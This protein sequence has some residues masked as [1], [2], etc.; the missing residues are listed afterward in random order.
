MSLALLPGLLSRA[1]DL[2]TLGESVMTATY[3]RDA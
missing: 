3:R 1:P 2:P